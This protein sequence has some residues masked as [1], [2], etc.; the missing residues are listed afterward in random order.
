MQ[1]QDVLVGDVWLCTGQ[2][3]LE[4]PV[5][6]AKDADAEKAAAEWPQLRHFAAGRLIA[7][8]PQVQT[9][10]KWLVCTQANVGIFSAVGYFFGRNP[11]LVMKRNR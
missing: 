1:S 4:Y 7:G 9:T 11:A 8:E 3:N 10:G 6:G 5:S 2:S